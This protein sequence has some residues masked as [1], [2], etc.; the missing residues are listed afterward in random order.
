MI[1][2]ALRILY[3][4]WSDLR[5]VSSNR[6]ITVRQPVTPSRLCKKRQTA[7]LIVWFFVLTAVYMVWTDKAIAAD[8]NVPVNLKAGEP[9]LNE[10]D[11]TLFIA[12]PIVNE[13]ITTAANVQV[14]SIALTSATRITPSAFP[15]ALGDI[16]ASRRAV[17][18]ASFTSNAL[19]PNQQYLLTV[20]GT[21]VL[22]NRTVRFVVDRDLS[23]PPPASGQAAVRSVSVEADIVDGPFPPVG[24]VPGEEHT[25]SEGGPPVPLGPRRG[26]ITPTSPPAEILEPIVVEEGLG[27]LRDSLQRTANPVMFLRNTPFGRTGLIAADIGDLERSPASDPSVA[28]S[29]DVV[30]ASGNRY[31]ALSTDGGR[32]FPTELDPTEIFR[33]P[34]NGEELCCDQVIHYVPSINR[35]VWTMTFK[36]PGAV[37]RASQDKARSGQS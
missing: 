33:N 8:P 35:F 1:Q 32:S 30:L 17:L 14:Q 34:D 36:P 7:I 13:G 28:S 15:V 6:S 22:G 19:V 25:E 3:R 11:G 12:L 2:Q 37:C 21:Y 5:F 20:E 27:T 16:G 18:D 4:L 31:I 10:E 29:G 26:S 24:I 9:G 23:L